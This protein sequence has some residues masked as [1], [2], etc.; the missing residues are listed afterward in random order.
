M[1]RLILAVSFITLF[2]IVGL[3]IQLILF[4]L[5]KAGKTNIKDHVSLA[6]VKWAF[7]VVLFICG[8]DI[9]VIGEENVPKDAPVLYIG[10]HTSFFDIVLTYARVPR[11]TGYI[12]KM[13]MNYVPALR[14]WMRY[15]H[16]LFL[17]RKD[18]RAGMQMLLDAVEN[19]KNGISMCIFPEGTRNTSGDE[20]QMLPFKEGSFKIASKS[21]CLILPMAITGAANIFE[22]QAPAIKKAHVI[23]EYGKPID[24][25]KLSPEDQKRPGAYTR[26]VIIEM[27][28]T[29]KEL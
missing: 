8:T 20:L 26:N 14:I 23:I 1:I 5:G 11:L 4:I 16:C 29:H 21:G 6:M 2:L 17:D 9:T 27:L 28:K 22:N 18:L 15:L 25:S 3:P 13:E 24:I 19:I 7:R 10:N 12:S